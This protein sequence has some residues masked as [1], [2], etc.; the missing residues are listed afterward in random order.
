LID[1]VLALILFT[2]WH[3]INGVPG[4]LLYCGWTVGRGLTFD[5]R[6]KVER[7]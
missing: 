5:G 4:L 2:Y 3:V 7:K 6:R 1:Y